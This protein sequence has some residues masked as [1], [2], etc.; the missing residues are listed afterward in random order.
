MD[1]FS[2]RHYSYDKLYRYFCKIG[3]Y[4]CTYAWHAIW[5]CA[6]CEFSIEYAIL[7]QLKCIHPNP[8]F[9]GIGQYA[10]WLT[11]KTLLCLL[12]SIRRCTE[13]STRH[14]PFPGLP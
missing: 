2:K 10:V 14:R 11:H 8:E 13:D 1:L 12:G 5:N 4:I 3:F 7:F 6:C 9:L